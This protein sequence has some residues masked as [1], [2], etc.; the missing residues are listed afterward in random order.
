[1]LQPKIE[2]LR[3]PTIAILSAYR[4]EYAYIC[5]K[6]GLPLLRT[7]QPKIFVTAFNELTL[8]RK[9]L[10]NRID[11]YSTTQEIPRAIVRNEVE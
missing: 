9:V 7:N 8:W 5:H 2:R 6:I 10:L 4:I 11:N 1:M 3:K